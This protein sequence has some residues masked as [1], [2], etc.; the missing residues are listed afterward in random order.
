MARRYVTADRDQGFL[1][2]PDMRDWLPESELAW[3]VLD[4]VEQL[5]LAGFESAYRADGAGRP[6]YDP[7]MMTALLLY[8]YSDGVRSS[9]QIE[10]RCERDIAYRVICGNHVP[11]HASIARFRARHR[12][13]LNGLF[14]QVLRMLAEAGMVRVGLIA[15]DGTKLRSNAR[16][17]CNRTAEQLEAEIADLSAQVE[18]LLAEADETDAAEDDAH[19][20]RRGDEPPED[21]ASRQRR[22][23]VLK[24]AKQR[25]DDEA[26]TAQAAQDA[27]RQQWERKRADGAKVGGPPGKTPPKP[28]RPAKMNLTDPDSKI[29]HSHGRFLQGYNGQ[30]VTGAGQVIVACDVTNSSADNPSLHPMLDLTRQN[31]DAADVDDPIRGCVGDSGYG[32]KDN[33]TTSADPI[34]LISTSTGRKQTDTASP[35]HP[36]VRKMA[37]RLQTPAGKRLYRRRAAM[38]EPVFGQIKN[39]LGEH[40]PFRGLD[41]VKAE[42]TLIC[43][44]HN[45]LKYWRHQHTAPAH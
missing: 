16:G 38:I 23:T 34:L 7:A 3:T 5:D 42:W 6:P 18:A 35:K 44:S 36:A 22:L 32:G 41:A 29:M 37:N 10:R 14:V 4:A 2:P 26:A 13:A 25:L 11:D 27:K 17:T 1:L 39:R 45:L 15:I 43:T 19:G 9:R 12:D 40:L 31:L 30:A 20:D 24:E 33:L 28:E 8:A 21:L